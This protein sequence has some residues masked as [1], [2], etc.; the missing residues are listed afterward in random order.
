MKRLELPSVMLRPLPHSALRL[1]G[2]LALALVSACNSSEGG[3]PTDEAPGPSAPV[4]PGVPELPPQL[5]AR[6]AAPAPSA[7]P[8]AEAVRPL[9]A[10]PKPL[11]HTGPWF[12]VTSPAAG[13]YA[14]PSMER[15]T[16]LGWVRSGGRLP[17]KAETVS[18]K[19]CA[20]GWYEIV[21][22]GFV[23]GTY[24]TTNLNLPDVKFAMAAPKLD[25]VLPYT[26]ARNAKHGTPLY[27]SVPSHEQ[28]LKYEPYLA[29]KD[30]PKPEADAGAPVAR[31]AS[32]A[33]TIVTGASQP[34][35]GTNAG[36]PVLDPSLADAGIESTEPEKPWWQQENIKERLHEVKLEH[37]EADADD[38]LAKRMVTG[39]FVAVDR[40]FRWNE[41][42]WYKTTKGLI[43]P[44]ERFWQT[45]GSKFKGVE[46]DGALLKLPIAWGYGGRKQVATYS[47]DPEVKQPKSA[48]SIDKHVAISL[49]GKSLDLASTKYLET[50]EGTYLKAAHVRVTDPGPFPADLAPDE[51]WIDVDLSSQTLVAFVGQKPVFATLIS[52]GKESKDKAK[53]HR[54]PTGEW[55]IREKHV[56]T[57]MDGDGS[58][59]GDLPY[60]IEDVPYVMYYHRAYAL[61]AAFWHGNYGVQ[62]SHGCVNLA[63]LD[64]KWL[65]FFAGPETRAAFHGVWSRPEA[66]GTRVVVHE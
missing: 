44:A 30:K 65:Y 34:A 21:D 41:R 15:S 51:R 27:K 53:D 49:T 46:L 11:E 9:S 61:H 42:T 16:K 22:G 32:S 10:F 64:A 40:T 6:S 2:P 26:Y 31:A 33:P 45:A 58:A 13:V 56:T 5:R 23:C 55:R 24:G 4:Q 25:D 57:T 38:I 37:L 60:S 17:V 62:M 8:A 19:G 36:G 1:L 63:P 66:P 47:I 12:V 28:M 39:F 20:P 7:P 48:K 43:T 54:T 3:S 18:K 59:A 50:A 35:P 52:S 14:E 29:E